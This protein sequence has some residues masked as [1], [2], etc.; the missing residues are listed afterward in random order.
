MLKKTSIILFIVFVNVTLV[1]AQAPVH[2][3]LMTNVWKL[4]AQ[5]KYVKNSQYKM[6]ASF[7]TPLKLLNNKVVELPGYIIP[8]KADFENKEFMLAVVPYDQCAYCG[9][10]DIPS[11]VE[12]HSPKGVP[13]SDKPVKIRGKLIL[14]ETGDSRSEIFIMDAEIVK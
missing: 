2:V 13:Y 4:I 8:I 11:M 7:P 3:P 14:N 10:G 12:V 1:K 5:K 6:V 9:Q